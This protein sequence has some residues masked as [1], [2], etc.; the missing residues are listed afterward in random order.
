[1]LMTLIV[2]IEDLSRLREII[3]NRTSKE[4]I[5]APEAREYI[6][7]LAQKI[8]DDLLEEDE[9]LSEDM[10]DTKP[11]W[12][13]VMEIGAGIPAEEWAKIPTDLSINTDHYL[14]GKPKIFIK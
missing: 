14:Y 6:Q 7:K 3:A 13:M 1:M 5:T 11:V 10:M 4:A 2:K 9:K 12:Q 8:V